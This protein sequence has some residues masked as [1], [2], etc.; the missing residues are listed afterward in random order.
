[1]EI[2]KRC[3]FIILILL[4]YQAKSQ[5]TVATTKKH[6]FAIYLGIGPSYY[7]NNIVSGKDLINEF[8]YSVDV[9]LMWEPEHFLSIGI[10]TGYYR[11]YTAKSSGQGNVHI[12]T[13]AVPIQTVVSMKLVKALYFDLALG[14]SLIYNNVHSDLYGDFNGNSVSLADLSGTLEYKVDLKNRFKIGLASKFF[15]SSHLN[16]K[17]LALLVRIGYKL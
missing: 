9:K 1:M 11:L 16:D 3:C 12:A 8:N 10:E 2:L 4:A 6:H 5:D 17:N 14:P 15:Y 7:F 13:I